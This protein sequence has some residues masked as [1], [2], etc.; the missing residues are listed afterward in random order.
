MDQLKG[1][2]NSLTLLLFFHQT[3]LLSLII[4]SIFLASDIEKFFAMIPL[5]PLLDIT[6]DELIK[7]RS[8]LTYEISE[9]DKNARSTPIRYLFR[10]K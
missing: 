10:F 4:L 1:K 7:R 8:T 6:I 2:R 9:N 5:D 3:F